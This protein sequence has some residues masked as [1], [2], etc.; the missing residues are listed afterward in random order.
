VAPFSGGYPDLI[1]ETPSRE[2]ALG[3]KSETVSRISIPTPYVPTE[4][5]VGNLD[6]GH[7]WS[8]YRSVRELECQINSLLVERLAKSEDK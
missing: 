5:H 3:K 6:A 2:L 8:H 7:S 4:W 1:S